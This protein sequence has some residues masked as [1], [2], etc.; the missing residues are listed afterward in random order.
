M[1]LIYDNRH[2][3]FIHINS[4]SS[5]VLLL[6][7]EHIDFQ[8]MFSSIASQKHKYTCIHIFILRKFCITGP[9]RR[10]AMCHV[11]QIWRTELVLGP[12]RVVAAIG[13]DFSSEQHTASARYSA[14][15]SPVGASPCALWRSARSTTSHL[16][17]S[18]EDA[19]R[20]SDHEQPW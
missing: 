10:N 19:N 13:C 5:E 8:N 15:A 12:G 9:D 17:A 18:C 16:V 6:L 14:F 2:I 1:S 7:L 3:C 20:S 11:L 4:Y